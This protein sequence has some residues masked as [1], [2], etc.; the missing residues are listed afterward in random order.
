MLPLGC[1][2]VVNRMTRCVRKFRGCS[3]GAASQPSGSKLPRHRVFSV[4]HHQ[5]P[6]GSLVADYR[7]AR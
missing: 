1:A 7:Q 6:P 2:A 5:S 4:W 3:F